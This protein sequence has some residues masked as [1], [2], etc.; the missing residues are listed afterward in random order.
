MARL[1]SSAALASLL[2]LGACANPH[3]PDF[4]VEGRLPDF[5]GKDAPKPATSVAE[6]PA[7]PPTTPTPAAPSPAKAPDSQP[8]PA[9]LAE[10][11]P[12]PIPAPAPTPVQPVTPQITASQAPIPAQKAVQPTKPV[13]TPAPVIAGGFSDVNDK[14]LIKTVSDFAMGAA[15]NGYLLKS[16]K[17]VQSQVVAGTNFE[18]C[19]RVRT[20]GHE[21]S[22]IRQR[23]VKAVVWQ[24]LDQTLELTSW[25]EVETCP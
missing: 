17:S 8:A 5:G 12:A 24:H 23:L 4:M 11:S 7:P 16:V 14:H 22:W 9:A 20:P 6:E 25:N 15:P 19:L 3:V 18:L 1:T 2:L 13:K 10:A 21:A